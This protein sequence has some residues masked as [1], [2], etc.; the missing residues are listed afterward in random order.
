MLAARASDIEGT[1]YNMYRAVPSFAAR[2]SYRPR[3]LLAGVGFLLACGAAAASLALHDHGDLAPYVAGAGALAYLVTSVV[4]MVP[5]SVP[6]ELAGKRLTSW[7]GE[8]EIA[9][10][11]LAS[12]VI[13]GV[14]AQTGVAVRVRGN[15]GGL[16]IGGEGHD[17]EGYTLRARPTRTVDCQLA[18]PD[19]DRLLAALGIEKGP[20]GP[21]V[22]PLVRNR[23]TVAGTLR[24]MVPLL[25]AMPVVSIVGVLVSTTTLGVWAE[26]ESGQLGLAIIT[27]SLAVLAVG[28][29]IVRGRRVRMP[30]RELRFD[31]DALVVAKGSETTRTAWPDVTIEKLRYQVTSRTGTFAMPVLVLGT[32][33]LGA[34][35]T[36]LDWPGDAGKTWRGPTWLV[37]AVKWPKLLAAL[38]RHGRL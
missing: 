16:W 19:F 1:F 37:G 24:A 18:K 31:D 15:G 8:I 36:A 38:Q 35:D 26:T 30:E 13:A 6:L 32:L 9:S 20:P 23:Q 27:V 2:R 3:V 21:L 22:V 33:R 12:W 14:D 34:W 7:A 29:M 10:V 4:A 5:H 28:W 11:E 17:G 25:I